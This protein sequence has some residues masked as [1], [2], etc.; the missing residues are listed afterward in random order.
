MSESQEVMNSFKEILY[1]LLKEYRNLLSQT[2]FTESGLFSQLKE[3]YE[4]QLQ[5]KQMYKQHK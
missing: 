2:N 3:M 5:L 4:M 1:L